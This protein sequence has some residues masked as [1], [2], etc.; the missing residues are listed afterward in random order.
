MND[1]LFSYARNIKR[2]FLLFL[3]VLI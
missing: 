1:L 3:D 2:M